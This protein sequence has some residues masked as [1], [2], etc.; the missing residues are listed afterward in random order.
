[1]GRMADENGK[2]TTMTEVTTRLVAVSNRLP[3][4]I[5]REGNNLTVRPGSGGLITAMAPVLRNRGGLW[6]G[7]PGSEGDPIPEEMML[8]ASKEA[9]Y[10]LKSVNLTHDDVMLYYYGFSNEVLWPLF[11]DLQSRCNFN[12]QYWY[13]YMEVNQKFASAVEENTSEKDYIWIHDYHLM[14]V[15]HVFRMKKDMRKLGFFLHIPFPPVDIF[16]KLPWRAQ[17]LH[18]LLDYDLIG[19]QTMRDRRNFINCLQYLNPGIKTSGRGPV[20]SVHTG[21]REVR[22]GSFPISIDFEA[23]ARGAASKAVADRAWYLREKLPN[24][25]IILGIDR[26]DYTKGIPERLLAFRNALERFNDMHG[27]ATLVLIV[28]PSRQEVQEYSWLKRDIERMVGEINGIFT[29]PGWVPVHYMYRSLTREELLSYYRTSEISLITP[30]KDGMNLVAK[31]YCACTLEE[32]GVVILSE[33]A[34]AA[35]QM[36]KDALLVNP[37]DIEGVANAIHE[38]FVMPREERIARMKRLREKIRKNDVFKWV[39]SFLQAAFAITLESL[40][41]IDEYVPDIDLN[42]SV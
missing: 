5:K 17:I 14:H 13:R 35:S 1:M 33:F 28:V 40:P 8:S 26:L 12:P 36:Q 37:Y 30:L 4:S 9:G 19:F 2:G 22:L 6:I 7:W 23:F 39:D 24:R 42:I 32:N 16:M 11:H 29:R 20:V 3:I 21:A 10:D 15:A 25:Q 38:A 31:E 18:D 27:K 34:G 41:P